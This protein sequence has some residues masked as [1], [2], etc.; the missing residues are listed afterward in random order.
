MGGGVGGMRE[1]KEEQEGGHAWPQHRGVDMLGR[2]T[3]VCTCLSACYLWLAVEDLSGSRISLPLPYGEINVFSDDGSMRPGRGDGERRAGERLK[4]LLRS[5]SGAEE[6]DGSS[7]VLG[8]SSGTQINIS[9]EQARG[10]V[11]WVRSVIEM[12]RCEDVTGRRS[13]GPRA[14]S[15]STSDP[16]ASGSREI[17]IIRLRA[18]GH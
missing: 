17:S 2:S 1:D 13:S 7:A 4:F 9:L 14:G 8:R 18:V 15:R 5:T 3:A 11:R 6:R 16:D 10:D 12:W